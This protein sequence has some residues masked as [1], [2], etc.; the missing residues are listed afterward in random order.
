MSTVGAGGDISWGCTIISAVIQSSAI[1]VLSV[2]RYATGSCS[3]AA[4][5]WVKQSN[6]KLGLLEE[7]GPDKSHI[8]IGSIFATDANKLTSLGLINLY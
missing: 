7:W 8:D 3:N 1:D 4:T 2:R 5:L 6:G